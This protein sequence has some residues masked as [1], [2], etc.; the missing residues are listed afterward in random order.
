VTNEHEGRWDNSEYGAQRKARLETFG[1]LLHSRLDS[2]L[3]SHIFNPG[4]P[5][6]SDVFRSERRLHLA[7]ACRKSRAT[8]M[9]FL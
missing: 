4:R 8:D 3:V 5:S 7:E 9:H 6:I 2:D 1:G